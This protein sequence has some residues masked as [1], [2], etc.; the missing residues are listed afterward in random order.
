V[1]VHEAGRWGVK[2]FIEKEELKQKQSFIHLPRE[3]ESDT[4]AQAE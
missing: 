1:S 2:D 3:E 4:K